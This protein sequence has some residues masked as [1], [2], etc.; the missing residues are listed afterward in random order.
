MGFDKKALG[1]LA[2]LTAA[3]YLV[4]PEVFNP[5]SLSLLLILVFCRLSSVLMM[6][7]MMRD[8][9]NGD[10]GETARAPDLL[11]MTVGEPARGTAG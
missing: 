4:G 2:V 11:V 8:R 7:M 5:A 3:V 9:C 6:K 1:V 10:T